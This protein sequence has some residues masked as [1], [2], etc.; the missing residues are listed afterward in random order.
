MS[1]KPW[2]RRYRLARLY[3]THTQFCDS[4]VYKNVKSVLAAAVALRLGGGVP[5]GFKL[6][7]YR[8]ALDGKWCLYKELA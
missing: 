8:T 6:C 5:T 2:K 4:S 3:H 1:K 7:I